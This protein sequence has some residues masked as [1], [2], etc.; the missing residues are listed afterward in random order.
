MLK[1]LILSTVLCAALAPTVASADTSFI[2]P[3][4]KLAYLALTGRAPDMDSAQRWSIDLQLVPGGNTL[5]GV[6]NAV[7]ASLG[8]P[9]AINRA[10]SLA[11]RA[12]AEQLYG[13]MFCRNQKNDAS[14][15][16]EWVDHLSTGQYPTVG[17][18]VAKMNWYAQQ[19][20]ANVLGKVCFTNRL[21]LSEETIDYQ[22]KNNVKLSD[23]TLTDIMSGINDTPATA[24]MARSKL[25]VAVNAGLLPFWDNVHAMPQETK[26]SLWARS[27]KNTGYA[28]VKDM[29]F[30]NRAHQPVRYDTYLPAAFLSRNDWPA[31]IALHGGGWVEGT[32]E[33]MADHAIALALAGYVV[34]VP[35]YRMG[36][37]FKHPSASNDIED[38]ALVASNNTMFG[39][40][41]KKFGV[42]G[43]SAGGHLAAYESLKYT[44]PGSPKCTTT[45]Y[46]PTNLAPL[47]NVP[48][49]PPY[50][51]LYFYENLLGDASPL[52]L[53]NRPSER[54]NTAEWLMLHGS[55]DAVV[56]ASQTV[57]MAA[58][59]KKRGQTVSY[60][61]YN[62]LGHN[63]G[64]MAQLNSLATEVA[65]FNNCMAKIK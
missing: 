14:G 6:V 50:V 18:V 17:A 20:P 26:A 13:N 58:A 24:T 61:V 53:A 65:F 31:V 29:Q 9:V 36:P 11:N 12:L 41:P 4:L 10:N 16:Q 52:V 8:Q 34:L 33:Y 21:A 46:A 27:T 30:A 62:G 28:V 55:Q 25:S 3:N 56:P 39:T 57:E 60:T 15:I 49:L 7:A 22:L 54:L 40:H 37:T 45:Y 19:V 47:L 42:V 43:A 35:N 44:G 2:N 1:K 38:L 63:W 48:G 59:L 23:K 5:E 32:K 51:K 64:G